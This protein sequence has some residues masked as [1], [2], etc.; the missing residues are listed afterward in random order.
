MWNINGTLRHRSHGPANLDHMWGF[1]HPTGGN[2]GLFHQSDGLMHE[3][4][5]AIKCQIRIEAQC[6]AQVLHP[7]N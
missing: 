2:L 7:G 3:A 5:L 6:L 1:H 4:N